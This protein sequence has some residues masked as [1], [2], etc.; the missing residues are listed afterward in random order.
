MPHPLYISII[1]SPT[2]SYIPLVKSTT[3]S[4]IHSNTK[5]YDF[6][7]EQEDMEKLDALDQGDAGAISWN[8]IHEK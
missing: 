1:C 5:L 8:P 6:V 2:H 7:L 4:R 3:P